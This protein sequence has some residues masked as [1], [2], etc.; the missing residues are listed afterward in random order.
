VARKGVK[1][2]F[3]EL[4]EKDFILA[5]EEMLGPVLNKSIEEF[6]RLFVTGR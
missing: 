2:R 4:I 6:N 5:D 3:P 1:Q